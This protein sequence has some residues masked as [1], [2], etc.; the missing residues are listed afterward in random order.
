MISADQ[1]FVKRDMERSRDAVGSRHNDWRV[2]D[3]PR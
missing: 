1:E 2:H 3:E